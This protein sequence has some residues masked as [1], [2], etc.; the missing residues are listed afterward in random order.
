MPQLAKGGKFVFGWSLLR[1]DYTVRIP[2][3]AVDEYKIACEGKSNFVV[4]QQDNRG[5]Y[6]ISKGA[7]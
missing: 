7:S 6:G 1:D 4:R 2:D 5:L 3:M